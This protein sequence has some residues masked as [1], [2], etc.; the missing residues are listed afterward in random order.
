MSEGIE[1]TLVQHLLGVLMHF[2]LSLRRLGVTL[3]VAV[4]GLG[5]M[6]S[7]LSADGSLKAVLQS[8][9][10]VMK[11]AMA[12]HD[13]TAVDALLAPDF[14]SIDLMGQSETGAQLIAEVNALKPDPNKESA[15][16]LLSVSV[17]G[18][19][20]TVKQRYDMKTVK[21]GE[22]G[23]QHNVELITV[24]TDTWVKPVGQW[25]IERTV[26][27]E[28]SYYRDGQLVGHKQGL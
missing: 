11:S 21:A 5:P 28:M 6:E 2:G 26:T 3:V 8:R 27:N 9:Y 16:T 10:A 14:V 17:S 25:L 12:A 13:G 24:S 22:D 7:A 15:T 1:A 23:V 4:A 20:A 18:N 19:S